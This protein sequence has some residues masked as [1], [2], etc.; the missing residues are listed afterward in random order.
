MLGVDFGD[1]RIGLAISD[2]NRK[3]AFPL[4]TYTRQ[5]RERDAAYFRAVIA[6]ERVAALV[7]GLPVHLDG[8]ESGKSAEARKFG[9]WLQTI[10]GI[11]VVYFDERF[12]SVEAEQALLS[13]EFTKKQRKAN[14]RK[15]ARALWAKTKL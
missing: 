7:V 4:A 6:E 10:T 15:A 13:A 5:G 14:D 9:E 11:G 3:I 8:H 12:T 2:P 1:V